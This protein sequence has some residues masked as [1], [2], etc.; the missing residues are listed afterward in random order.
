M[1]N[2]RWYKEEGSFKRNRS[3][4]TGRK[5]S[6]VMIDNINDYLERMKR[7]D[8]YI[9]LEMTFNECLGYLR[10]L[11]NTGA[12]N[13]KL[14]DRYFKLLLN[15]NSRLVLKSSGIKKRGW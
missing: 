7:C 2:Y 9:G 10:A 15:M 11:R 4:N 13:E 5:I 12:I 8:S 3:V 14:Y 1:S 6:R